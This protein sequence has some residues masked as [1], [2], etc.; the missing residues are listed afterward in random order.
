MSIP[1]NLTDNPLDCSPGRLFW[2][3]PT[4][5]C[6]SK[7]VL[8]SKIFVLPDADFGS[9]K[10]STNSLFVGIIGILA[11]LKKNFQIDL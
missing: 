7:P 10:P 4:T 2:K 5:P 3:S 8:T 9:F 6:F 11:S 1:L